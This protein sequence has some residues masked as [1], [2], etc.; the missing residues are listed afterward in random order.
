MCPEQARAPKTVDHRADIWAVGVIMYR[1][2]TGRLPFAGEVAPD[3]P[4]T[5]DGFFGRAL[6]KR[7]ED[8]FSSIVEMVEAFQII[9]GDVSEQVRA[10]RASYV[11]LPMPGF[12][13]PP[14][15]V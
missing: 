10:M 4:P 1:V 8:R 15:V 14:P 13:A 11:M 12:A 6:A 5:L 3:L 2:L 9:A 7:K